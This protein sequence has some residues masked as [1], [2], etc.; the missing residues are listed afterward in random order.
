[1]DLII[2]IVMVVGAV[3]WLVLL[4]RSNQKDKDYNYWLLSYDINIVFGLIVFIVLGMLY[5][6]RAFDLY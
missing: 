3:I 5:I 4:I 6:L 2:G 1:M